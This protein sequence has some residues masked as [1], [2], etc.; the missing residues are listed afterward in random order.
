MD[1][2]EFL[3]VAAEWATGNSEVEWRTAA[4]RAYFGAHHV[5]RQLLVRA[6]FA[7]PE[8]PAAHGAVW[9]R[10]ANAGQVDVVAAGNALQ[11]LRKVRN[12]A[13]YDLDT[14]FD[15]KMAMR[16]S[17]EADK[18]VQLLDQ[19]A[20]TPTVLAQV[21]T[22]IRSYEQNVLHDVTYRAP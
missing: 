7:I 16:Q 3:R 11:L 10:L 5:G 17:N 22:A 18:I 1:P 19:L 4:S 15:Q 12:Q 14:P 6:G 21:V 2:R 20:A 13:D 8:G 9:L